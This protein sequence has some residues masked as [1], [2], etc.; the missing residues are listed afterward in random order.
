MWR[1][2]WITYSEGGKILGAMTCLQWYHQRDPWSGWE[3]FLPCLTFVC[4]LS[5]IPALS[6]S[7]LLFS[8]LLENTTPLVFPFSLY[9][10][11]QTCMAIPLFPDF[12]ILPFLMSSILLFFHFS[13][14][15]SCPVYFFAERTKWL[16]TFTFDFQLHLIQHK[17]LQESAEGSLMPTI[18]WLPWQPWPL[19]NICPHV[20]SDGDRLY[21]SCATRI[22]FGL[23]HQNL[24]RT[25]C[26]FDLI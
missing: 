19:E 9:F 7:S 1:N 16:L 5:S 12:Q 13:L 25:I 2:V 11:N 18:H 24:P 14:P 20:I 15:V 22:A 4:F 10:R 3:Y 26:K 23:L 8:L 6:F 21:R 17:Q